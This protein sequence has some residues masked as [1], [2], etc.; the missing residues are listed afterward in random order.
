MTYT[1]L[2]AAVT[3]GAVACHI[4][5]RP[6]PLLISSTVEETAG[7]EDI[8][9]SEM[10]ERAKDGNNGRVTELLVLCGLA[11]HME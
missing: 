6:T 8:L 10:A 1:R 5:P 3:V 4:K 11:L 2:A 9:Q 7:K